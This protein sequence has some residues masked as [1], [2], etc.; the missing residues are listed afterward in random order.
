MLD[1]SYKLSYWPINSHGFEDGTYIKR[2][3]RAFE[4]RGFLGYTCSEI[5]DWEIKQIRTW[6]K[7]LDKEIYVSNRYTFPG[8]SIIHNNIKYY[9][10]D[11]YGINLYFH[12]KYKKSF[13]ELIDSFPER[14][15]IVTIKVPDGRYAANK[16]EILKNFKKYTRNQ[17]CNVIPSCTHDLPGDWMILQFSDRDMALEFK[18]A[19]L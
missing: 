6:A 2:K 18:L 19:A 4:K 15:Y 1:D 10:F 8:E 11:E 3:M 14:K 5:S 7:L 12:P 16:N 17:N 9:V 13:I